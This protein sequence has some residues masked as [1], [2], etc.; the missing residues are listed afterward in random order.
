MADGDTPQHELTDDKMTGF[1]PSSQ[2]KDAEHCQMWPG[3]D[4]SNPRVQDFYALDKPYE[5]M[6]NR[7][8]IPRMPWH[9]ISMQLVG[10]PVRDLARHFVQRWNYVL[11]QRKTYSTNTD[12]TASA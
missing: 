9:D 4:Y 5:E 12:A 6:Y 11:R 2:P 8:K 1:E 10:Q 3:K 7:S